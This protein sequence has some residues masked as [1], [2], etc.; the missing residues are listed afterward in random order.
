MF[1]SSLVCYEAELQSGETR[2]KTRGVA[3][4]GVVAWCKTHTP[5]GEEQRI[6]AEL[7][8]SHK[9]VVSFRWIS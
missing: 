7:T 2:W 4:V 5:E 9:T 1:V 3:R 8:T 6:R